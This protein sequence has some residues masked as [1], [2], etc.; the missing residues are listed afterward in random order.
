MF[1]TNYSSI[2]SFNNIRK[3]STISMVS[4]SSS[5][6]VDSFESDS[7]KTSNNS[8]GRHNTNYHHHIQPSNSYE[9]IVANQVAIMPKIAPP[10]APP[11]P[12]DYYY[13]NYYSHNNPHAYPSHHHDHHEAPRHNDL[14]PTGQ[15][16]S[17]YGHQTDWCQSQNQ[18]HYHHHHHHPPSIGNH[19]QQQYANTSR[20]SSMSCEKTSTM[21]R[22]K[23]TYPF[24]KCKVC[25]DK[26]TGVHYGIA[27]CEGWWILYLF[28]I[29]IYFIQIYLFYYIN[30][31]KDARWDFYTFRRYFSK[32]RNSPNHI[33]E[34]NECL[35]LKL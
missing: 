15:I 11:V 1:S 21:K 18:H 23:S 33:V 20:S 19:D 27:T 6:P 22:P 30:F 10:L 28:L 17:G 29:F 7:S 4:N 34:I 13:R 3:S 8:D 25:S 16:H 32:K 31:I 35:N 5:S 12:N 14:L 9:S 26:A 2:D 24:G